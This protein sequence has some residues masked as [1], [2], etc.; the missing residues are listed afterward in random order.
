MILMLRF[1][2]VLLSWWM[3]PLSPNVIRSSDRVVTPRNWFRRLIFF[4]FF[5][6]K[7][8]RALN[9]WEYLYIFFLI[10]TWLE[11][12]MSWTHSTAPARSVLST[13]ANGRLSE[14]SSDWS[15]HDL[16]PVRL[17]DNPP[18]AQSTGIPFFLSIRTRTP[19]TQLRSW[20]A[21]CKACFSHH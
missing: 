17:E 11:K 13:D 3:L 21:A 7:N 15:M 1:L 19:F 10:L 14:N 12:C 16:W 4:F 6:V 5:R 20:T 9:V 8:A 2:I 18:L